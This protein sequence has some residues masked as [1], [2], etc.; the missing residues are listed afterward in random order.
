MADQAPSNAEEKKGKFGAIKAII[1]VVLIMLIEVAV[2]FVTMKMSGGPAEVSGDVIN[3]VQ[4]EQ[5]KIVEIFVIKEKFYND[6]SGK[7]HI[8]D[9]E[10]YITTRKRN[11]QRVEQILEEQHAAISVAVNGVFARADPSIF[12]EPTHA[13]LSRQ[14]KVQLDERMGVDAEGEPV[15]QDVLIRKCIPYPA[16]Y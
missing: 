8:Y 6:R 11:Q 12:Q 9:S 14:V 5:N 3:Q 13:T 15:V 1:A 4:A 16:H 7:P 2:I 10:I